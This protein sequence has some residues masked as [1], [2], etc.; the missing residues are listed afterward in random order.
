MV[1]HPLPRCGGSLCLTPDQAANAVYGAKERGQDVL[2][3]SLCERC[4]TFH[5]R[6]K[7][8]LN[9]VCDDLG[10]PQP[11]PYTVASLSGTYTSSHEEVR[12]G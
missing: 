9:E 8:S 5:M 6:R 3:A 7:K 1:D 2:A 12:R 10:L 4:G 11:D